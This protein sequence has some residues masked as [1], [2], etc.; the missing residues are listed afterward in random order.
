M[1]GA[2]YHVTTAAEWEAAKKNG[3]YEAASLPVEG[4]IHCSTEKQVKGVLE[5]YFSGQT[6]LVKLVI[7]PEKL[8]SKLQYDRSEAMNEDFPHIY[9][10]I[11]LDAV[12]EVEKIQ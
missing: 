7:D 4:F 9:G 12:T 11:N 5:R 10:P 8:L 6:E 3:A 1:T 2:I